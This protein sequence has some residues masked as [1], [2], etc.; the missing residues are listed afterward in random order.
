MKVDLGWMFCLV[1]AL[2]MAWFVD[3]QASV[4]WVI[5]WGIGTVGFNL[6]FGRT[7]AAK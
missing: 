1:P 7:N 5:G 4:G 3:R 2:L 6:L